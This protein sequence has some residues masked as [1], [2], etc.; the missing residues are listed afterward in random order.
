MLPL[1]Q[2][3]EAKKLAHIATVQQK[4]QMNNFTRMNIVDIKND[5]CPRCG[6]QLIIRTAKKGK[7]QGKKFRGCSNY[8]GCR[9][10][11]NIF[12]K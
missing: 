10:I 1:T 12:E 3:D 7:W 4:Q 8:P 9:Y 11:E 5:K 2:I 6:G